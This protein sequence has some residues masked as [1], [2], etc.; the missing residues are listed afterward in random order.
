MPSQQLSSGRNA[1]LPAK[2]PDM[3]L[4]EDVNPAQ[5]TPLYPSLARI[6]YVPD[7]ELHQARLQSSRKRLQASGGIGAL[8]KDWPQVFQGPLAWS[9]SDVQINNECVYNLSQ[10]D[11]KEIR[12]GLEYCKG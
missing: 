11:I 6:G 3:E 5:H 1:G 7:L 12:S 10:M 4:Q 8:P 2:F 9:G